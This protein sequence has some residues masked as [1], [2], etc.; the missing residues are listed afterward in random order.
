MLKEAELS[1]NASHALGDPEKEQDSQQESEIEAPDSSLDTAE[2]PGDTPSPARVLGIGGSAARQ[3]EPV[4][5]WTREPA[6]A[7]TGLAESF[8]A[9]K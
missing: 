4:A 8:F 7:G 5:A 1:P 3:A 9:P 2:Q 6:E